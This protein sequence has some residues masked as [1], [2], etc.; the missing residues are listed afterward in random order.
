MMKIP[1]KQYRFAPIGYRPIRAMFAVQTIAI[2]SCGQFTYHLRMDFKVISIHNILVQFMRMTT[3]KLCSHSVFGQ[4]LTICHCAAHKPPTN[5]D[6]CRRH[7]LASGWSDR[8]ALCAAAAM[9]R[10][11][12]SSSKF[13]FS[14]TRTKRTRSVSASLENVC[15]LFNNSFFTR[16]STI[17]STS[18]IFDLQAPGE[19]DR[20]IDELWRG[21]W[22]LIS[23]PISSA[24]AELC[25]KSR[26]HRSFSHQHRSRWEGVLTSLTRWHNVHRA[27]IMVVAVAIRFWHHQVP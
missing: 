5:G 10:E 4:L 13:S 11:T 19:R 22:A 2:G 16:P 7:A 17:H 1:G 15:G 25:D 8:R 23:S 3:N 21:N 18:Y 27:Y 6:G 12:G 20:L 26:K 14:A 9:E 24:N